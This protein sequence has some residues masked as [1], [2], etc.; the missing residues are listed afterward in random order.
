MKV[1]LVVILLVVIGLFLWQAILLVRDIVRKVKAKKL[2]KA[3]DEDKS[4]DD[5]SARKE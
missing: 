5:N 4:A 1:F 3:V 2:K